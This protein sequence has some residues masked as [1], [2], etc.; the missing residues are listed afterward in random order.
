MTILVDP[1]GILKSTL[2]AIKHVMPSRKFACALRQSDG[3]A[4]KHLTRKHSQQRR[5][6][7]SITV[8][9]LLYRLLVMSVLFM[10]SIA[11]NG[12]DRNNNYFRVF[13]LPYQCSQ[14]IL[15]TYLA[16]R[17]CNTR[18]RGDSSTTANCRHVLCTILSVLSVVNTK[19]Y[20]AGMY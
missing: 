8:L 17:N 2:C 12:D 18:V 3:R 5:L 16:L 10:Q 13:C 15:H 14:Y 6:P 19:R 9:L 1:I 11:A 7:G 4:Q 20:K